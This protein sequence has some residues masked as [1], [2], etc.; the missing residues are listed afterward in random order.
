M[1][2]GRRRGAREALAAAAAI[3]AAAAAAAA[4]RADASRAGKIED[5][6]LP[7]PGAAF[8]SGR[9]HNGRARRFQSVNANRQELPNRKTRWLAAPK[10]RGGLMNLRQGVSIRISPISSRDRSHPRTGKSK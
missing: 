4:A 3:T 2:H 10:R 7:H 8:R 5:I 1:K 6:L 9:W